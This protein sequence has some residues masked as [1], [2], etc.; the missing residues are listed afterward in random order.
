F[1][2]VQAA[3]ARTI[4]ERV[5]GDSTGAWGGDRRAGQS[6]TPLVAICKGYAILTSC[7]SLR[8]AH[9]TLTTRL[10]KE[11]PHGSIAMEAQDSVRCGNAPH[12]HDLVR[13]I[14]CWISLRRRIKRP[15]S[16]GTKE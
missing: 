2:Y 15:T 16:I 8:D 1:C 12:R 10:K 7:R 11:F 3:S 14:L 5:S 13:R 9:L 4:G 6:Q